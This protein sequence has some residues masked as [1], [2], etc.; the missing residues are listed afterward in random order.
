MSS[1]NKEQDF[2]TTALG[3]RVEIV[4]VS[5]LEI[6]EIQH[7]VPI[8]EAPKRTVQTDVPGFTE[9]QELTEDTLFNDEERA[10]WAEYVAQRRAAE[11]E[12]SELVT[13]FLFLEGTRFDMTSLEQW[14][15]KRLRWRL[16]VP[17]DERDLQIAYY[18]TA[19]IGSVKDLNAIVEKVMAKQGVDEATLKQVS[20]TFQRALRR[21]AAGAVA[22]TEGEVELQPALSGDEGGK[23]VGSDPAE[24]VLP[25]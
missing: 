1:S 2:Y 10:T 20:A 17:E 13:N 23:G 8:P 18:R 9:I 6:D 15:A 25:V 4:G 12:R 19:V 14:K 3:Q 22:D 24:S 21:D 16:P 5:P 11:R 7:L